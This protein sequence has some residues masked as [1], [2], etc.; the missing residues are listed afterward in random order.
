MSRDLT[1]EEQE[2][3][4][5]SKETGAKKVNNKHPTDIQQ[6]AHLNQLKYTHPKYCIYCNQQ[7][8]EEG[9]AELR[10]YYTKQT[11]KLCT[12]LPGVLMLPIPNMGLCHFV[13]PKCKGI[14]M[15]EECYQNQ[16]IV[17]EVQASK[18]VRANTM[19]GGKNLVN[20]NCFTDELL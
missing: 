10:E 8:D 7:L 15:N 12:W 16:A 13:C 18:I 11:G 17:R 3:V 5:R 19:P 14:M 2:I 6:P 9:L 4:D 1:P 20:L